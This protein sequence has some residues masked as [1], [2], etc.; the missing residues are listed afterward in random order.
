MCSVCAAHVCSAAAA[1]R[2]ERGPAA[3]PHAS[4]PPPR[5]PSS[6]HSPRR[7]LQRPSPGAEASLRAE[8]PSRARSGW[9]ALRARPA[10]RVEETSRS[11]LRCAES[12]QVAAS[13]SRCK[14]ARRPR[15][16]RFRSHGA[17]RAS[18][19]QR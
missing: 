11:C 8:G 1:H 3:A 19:S 14:S 16:A 10:P 6:F 18:T 17:G 15:S 5:R 9:R 4:L 13:M 12:L 2:N 7:F